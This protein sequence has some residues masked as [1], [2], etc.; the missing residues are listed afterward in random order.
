[1]ILILSIIFLIV[2]IEVISLIKNNL[3]YKKVQ[4]KDEVKDKE[5]YKKISNSN[6]INVLNYE[7][8]KNDISFNKFNV[9]KARKIFL[10]PGYIY[11]QDDNLYLHYTDKIIY[12]ESN[13]VY[14]IPEN[15]YLEI[16]EVDKIVSYYY[17]FKYIDENNKKKP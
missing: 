12:M 4:V 14:E 9:I 1:M 13:K 15:F 3:V 2:T 8:V 6:I 16:L 11:T 10:K 7:S 5:N 17:I